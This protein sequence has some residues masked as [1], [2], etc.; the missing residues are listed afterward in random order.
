M[1]D[2]SRDAILVRGARQNNLKNLDLDIPLNELVVVTGVSGSGKSSLVFDTLYAEGQRRYV[3]TFSPVR[4]AVPR[5]HGQ[6]AGRQ[7]RGHSAGDR[8]RPDESGA[9]LAL[10]CRHDDRAERSPEVDICAGRG[11]ALPM[12]RRARPP[13][14]VGKHLRGPVAQ[15]R[16]SGRRSASAADVSRC[17]CRR[18]SRK[19]KCAGCSRSRATRASSSRRRRRRR[20]DAERPAAAAKPRK[21][22]AAQESCGNGHALPRSSKWCRTACAP[23]ARIAAACSS[24]SKPRCASDRAASTCTWS[25]TADPPRSAAD[26]ALFQRAA[27]R[28]MRSVVSRAEPQPVLVQLARRRLRDLP[29]LRP[30]HRHRL[31]PRHSR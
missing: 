2:A 26:L 8:D 12:L 3:E 25:T 1:T 5:P 18:T 4:A 7:H 11:T 21:A 16:E 17:R 24:R 19:R 29:R 14:Y 15:P 10:H 23:A 28:G 20:R 6:A 13:R 9:H 30:H 31:R 27:L 22:R